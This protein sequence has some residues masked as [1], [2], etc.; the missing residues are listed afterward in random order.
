MILVHFPWGS[1]RPTEVFP[2]EISGVL[3][4]EVDCSLEGMPVS[5]ADVNWPDSKTHHEKNSNRSIPSIG[6]D[7]GFVDSERMTGSAGI[8]D[9]L[10]L[11]LFRPPVN[12]LSSRR[13]SMVNLSEDQICIQVPLREEAVAA[14]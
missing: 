12:R 9:V 3:S 6:L 11:S 5:T 10:R 1:A 8:S 14:P 4:G 2:V 13:H 7:G